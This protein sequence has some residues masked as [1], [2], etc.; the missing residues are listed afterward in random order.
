MTDDARLPWSL[1]DGRTAFLPGLFGIVL[2]GWAWWDASGTGG[3]HQQTRALA[4]AVLGT[5]VVGAGCFSWVAAGRRAV[6]SRRV[7]VIDRLEQLGMTRTSVAVEADQTDQLVT[8]PGTARYHRAG[9]VLIRGKPV[10]RHARSQAGRS[11]C[12]MCRP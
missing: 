11:A 1:S 6:R 5:G 10:E 12:E 3:L 4:V 8:V 9:C 7:Q 2:L